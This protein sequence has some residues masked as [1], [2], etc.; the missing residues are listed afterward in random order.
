VFHF[1]H[2]LSSRFVR[3]ENMAFSLKMGNR[4]AQSDFSTTK[5]ALRRCLLLAGTP[6]LHFLFFS[7]QTYYRAKR[8]VVVTHP[9]PLSVPF[10]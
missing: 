8:F 9:H 4:C 10:F 7:V 3:S 1:V 5:T 2:P 6:L